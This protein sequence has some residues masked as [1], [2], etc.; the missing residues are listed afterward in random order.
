MPKKSKLDNVV[1]ER[2]ITLVQDHPQLYDV[3]SNSYKD[4]GLSSNIW[5]S[6]AKLLNVADV[7]GKYIDSFRPIYSEPHKYLYIYVGL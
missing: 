4:T 5:E 2:L 7:D 3:S 6:I 1:T